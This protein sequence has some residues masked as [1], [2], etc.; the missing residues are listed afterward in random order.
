MDVLQ[1]QKLL[2]I[3][4][5]QK[6]IIIKSIIKS[7]MQSNGILNTYIILEPYGKINTRGNIRDGD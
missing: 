1:F 4:Y 2:S 7:N 3:N 6:T 5:Y